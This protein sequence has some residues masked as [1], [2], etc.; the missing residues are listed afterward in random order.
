[1][2]KEN[3]QK[4]ISLISITTP[5]PNLTWNFWNKFKS[6]P[7]HNLSILNT[8]F[9]QLPFL[10]NPR[11]HE[12]NYFDL[13]WWYPTLICLL[14]VFFI[15][16]LYTDIHLIPQPPRSSAWPGKKLP[17]NLSHRKGYTFTTPQPPLK[18]CPI[19]GSFF[20]KLFE[21]NRLLHS[22]VL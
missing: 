17:K 14:F 12:L 2:A 19:G 15:R 11:F 3:I 20:I 16:Y 21:V 13:F 9:S 6:Y 10:I 7:F 22:V 1:M 8:I 5:H 18:T 4:Y